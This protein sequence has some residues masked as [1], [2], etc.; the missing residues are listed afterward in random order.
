MGR[1][2]GYHLVGKAQMTCLTGARPSKRTRPS[3]SVGIGAPHGP[4]A[5]R[6]GG[7]NVGVWTGD[8]RVLFPRRSA[9]ARVPWEYQPQR[10]DT[11]HFN[12]DYKPELARGGVAICRLD[13]RTGATTALTRGEPPVWDFRASESPDGR[14]VAFCRAETGGVPAIWVMDADG[15]NAR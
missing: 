2:Y 4:P 14:S 9:G 1:P 6:G 7:S 3:S 11:D 15:R 8:G 10:P 5:S 12:R 13:P